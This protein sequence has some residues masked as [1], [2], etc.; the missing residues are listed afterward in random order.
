MRIENTSSRQYGLSAKGFAHV[1][2]PAAATTENG[3]KT[4]GFADIDPEMLKI[5]K[6]EAW[7][8][9]VFAAG[10]LIEVS[11]PQTQ[12]SSTEETAPAPK[13]KPAK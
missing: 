10:D 3:V 11:P 1:A 8:Q 13:G 6:A 12:S 9:A 7:G 5:V 4:N 2:V